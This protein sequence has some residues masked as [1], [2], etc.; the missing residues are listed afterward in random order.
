M[1]PSRLAGSSRVACLEEFYVLLL[2]LQSATGLRRLRDCNGRMN[3]PARGVYFFLD[4]QEQRSDS[5]DVPRVVR[6]GTHALTTTSRTTVGNRLSQHRG[7]ERSPGG[8]HRGSIF[9]LLVGEALVT[10]DGI[11]CATWG[12]GNNAPREV[13]Q[14][15]RPI[16]AQ[17]SS[18]IGGLPFLWLTIDDPPG[19]NSLRGHI[20]RNAI[21]LLS[22]R[23]RT[24]LDAPGAG[25]LGSHSSRSKVQE[26]GLWNQ[27]HV[28]E[29]FD[30][31]F[32]DTMRTLVQR[33]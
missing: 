29:D 23:Q 15:E 26:S 25:W 9:R 17:V 33:R 4:D 21:A 19:P 10:R 24:A 2:Q 16:E 13:R 12:R 3:W 7:S 14:S 1:P 6:V 30:P 22:N 28:D 32:L 11:D 31:G 5:N 27:N 18:Y 20:E 8:N